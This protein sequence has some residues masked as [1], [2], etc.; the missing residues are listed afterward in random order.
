MGGAET[1]ASALDEAR[2]AVDGRAWRRAHERYASIAAGTELDP[3]DLERFAKS[4]YWTGDALGAIST[5]EAAYERY[6]ERGDIAAAAFSAL[7]LQRQHASMLHDSVAAA[8]LRRAEH[9]LEGGET[10]RGNGFLAIAH[11]DTARARGDIAGALALVE[12]AQVM[13]GR[14]PDLD[15][16]AWCLMRRGMFLIDGGRIAEGRRQLEEVAAAAA[17]G[18]LG[19]FTTGAILS[20]VASVY[21]DLGDLRRGDEWSEAAMRWCERQDVA[22]FPGVCRVQRGAILRM[23]GRL[24]EAEGELRTACQELD[25]FSPAHAGAAHHELGEVRLRTGDL[26][27]AE[28]S[29]RRARELGEDPQPGLALLRL[30]QGDIDGASTSIRRS[31]QAAAFDLFARAR[32]LPAQAE[33]AKAAGDVQL[34]RATRDELAEIV[35]Q[36]PTPAMQAATDWASGLLALI[37]R[38]PRR[39]TEHLRDSRKGWNETGAPYESARA[40]VA[41]AEAHLADGD[42]EAAVFE[43]DEAVPV[44]ERLGAWLDVRRATELRAQAGREGGTSRA[45]R[46][47]LFTDIVGSTSL[48]EVIGDDAWNDL[49]RWHDQTLRS[50][51]DEHGGEEIDHAGDGFFVAFPDPASAVT[52]AVDMQRRLTEHRRTQGFAP[53][54]R[55][56][57]HAAAA[58]RDRTGYV[59]LGVHAASRIAAL[60]GAGEIL[61]SVETLEDVPGVTTSDL[62]SVVLKGIAD[63]IE[64]VSIDWRPAGER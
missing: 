46:T 39:A 23:L 5:R 13:A 19:S 59:G 63:P 7:T 32:M 26:G 10:S 27:G 20:N 29:F 3:D 41:L 24:G 31:L 56:G 58:T 42:D 35:V 4:A 17:G 34:T 2:E 12:R 21:R 55:M 53:H 45:I 18:G 22:G 9:L 37:E 49:R 38:D 47:F 40:A 60:A 50:S 36:I 62:R 43:V 52:C 28:E 14:I 54:V 25:G 8:W 57:L 16:P 64:I 1:S 48:I 15:L 11:A 61:A 44:L 30:A 6:L 33:I 51:F